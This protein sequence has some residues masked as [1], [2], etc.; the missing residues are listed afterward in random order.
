M[1][2]KQLLTVGLEKIMWRRHPGGSHADCSESGSFILNA[3]FVLSW[4]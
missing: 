1:L 2:K 3:A 4:L